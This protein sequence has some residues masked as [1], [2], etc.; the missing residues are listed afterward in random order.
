MNL[1]GSKPAKEIQVKKKSIATIETTN[2][3]ERK[4]TRVDEQIGE[5]SLTGHQRLIHYLKDAKNIL[6]SDDDKIILIHNIIRITIAKDI[7]L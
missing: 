6:I 1:F 3:V 4:V 5:L 7:D 2:D